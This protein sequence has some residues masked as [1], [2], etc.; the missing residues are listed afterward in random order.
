MPPQRPSN[1]IYIL[2]IYGNT[3]YTYEFFFFLIF[4]AFCLGPQVSQEA[5][6]LGPELMDPVTFYNSDASDSGTG[7]SAAS[8]DSAENS[9]MAPDYGNMEPPTQTG[10]PVHACSASLKDWNLQESSFTG[11]AGVS[12]IE[13]PTFSTASSFADR[14]AH[15]VSDCV[16]NLYVDFPNGETE[17]QCRHVGEDVDSKC[18]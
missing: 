10:S 13:I 3:V 11:R 17:E 18:M 14:D 16:D 2:R 5:P 4:H 1:Y 15:N 9:A 6:S 7:G 12:L 8:F